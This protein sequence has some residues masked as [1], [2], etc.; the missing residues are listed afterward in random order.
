MNNQGWV[1]I[2]RKLLDSGL[3]TSEKFTKGQ[4]WVDLILLANREPHILTV[5]G[6][7]VKIIT[8]QVGW[9]EDS[10]ASR[11]FW[12]RMKVRRFKLWLKRYNRIDYTKSNV[13]S[14]ISILNY[15]QYQNIGQ[16]TIQQTIQQKDNRRYTNNNDNKEDNT[17]NTI[18]RTNVQYGNKYV[19]FVL[20]E[21]KRRVGISPI[22]SN[23]RQIAYNVYQLTSSFIKKQGTAYKEKRGE[24]AT[25]TGLVTRAWDVYLKN[26]GDHLPQRLKTFKEHYKG[27][28]EKLSINLT[29]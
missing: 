9:S 10:L 5:R 28:L 8:G 3:W 6:N 18:S 16:Q 27:M 7:E 13:L 4:A 29:A 1:S 11:W 21:F 20:D 2:H 22:D 23:S 26:N 25:F 15:E 14:V 17:N 24:E 12:S 19:L